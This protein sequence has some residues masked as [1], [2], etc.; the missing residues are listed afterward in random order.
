MLDVGFGRSIERIAQYLILHINFLNCSIVNCELF[1]L[2]N[3]A[4]I[5]LRTTH[6]SVHGMNLVHYNIP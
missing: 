6:R 2:N 3:I 1:R 5:G 4:I